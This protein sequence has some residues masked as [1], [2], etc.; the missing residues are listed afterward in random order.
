V[1]VAAVLACLALAQMELTQVGRGLLAVVAVR[2]AQMD[3]LV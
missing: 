2:V 1:V 3:K